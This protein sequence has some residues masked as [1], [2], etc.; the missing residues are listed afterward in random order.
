MIDAPIH[1][2]ESCDLNM[3]LEHVLPLCLG[4]TNEMRNL[5][6]ACHQCNNSKGKQT[7]LTPAWHVDWAGDLCDRLPDRRGDLDRCGLSGD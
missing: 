5:A 7:D 2:K 4:G 3:T 6:L 1:P